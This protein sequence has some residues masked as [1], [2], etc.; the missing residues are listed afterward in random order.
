[1]IRSISDTI[2]VYSEDVADDQAGPAVEIHGQLC[3]RAI[4]TSIL[5]R[6]PVRGAT[7]FGEFEV[8]GN[9]YVSKA[10]DE[11]ASWH[12]FGDWIGVH[13]SPSALLAVDREVP[14]W[15]CYSPPLKGG[16]R[17]RTLCVNWTE[18]WK[19]SVSGEQPKRRLVDVFREMGPITPDFAMKFVNTLDYYDQ[20]LR[21]GEAAEAEGTDNAQ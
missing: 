8:Q 16:M 18:T 12:E 3:A 5:A 10:I 13:L 20:L 14:H 2:V 15:T 1:M 4:A 9:I 17:H 11:A 7:A 6:I 19:E 21:R